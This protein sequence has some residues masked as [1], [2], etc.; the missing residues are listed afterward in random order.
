MMKTIISNRAIVYARWML[1][2]T[3]MSIIASFVLILR[4]IGN[5]NGGIMAWILICILLISSVFLGGHC[6]KNGC[7]KY[8]ESV[9]VSDN[10]MVARN[11]MLKKQCTVSLE[12]PVYCYKLWW[13]SGIFVT[14]VWVVSNDRISTDKYTEQFRVLFNPKEQILL[15]ESKFAN[16]MIQQGAWIEEA[17]G[18]EEVRWF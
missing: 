7:M 2:S 1:L 5:F 9:F 17:A 3:V 6:W 12:K 4:L 10:M 11:L 18:S 14:N 16:N 13:D 15:T 8:I